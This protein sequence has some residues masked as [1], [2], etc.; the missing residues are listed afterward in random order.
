MLAIVG[1][2]VTA[3]SWF[4][5]NRTGRWPALYGFTEGVLMILALAMLS[6]LLLIMRWA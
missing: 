3:W 2:I 6:P 5:V 1:N 4:G